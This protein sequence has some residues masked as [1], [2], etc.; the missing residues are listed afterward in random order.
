[1]APQFCLTEFDES[2]SCSCHN[3]TMKFSQSC[4]GAYTGYPES[5]GEACLGNY[6][7]DFTGERG[8]CKGYC[9]KAFANK[10]VERNMGV[11]T[12]DTCYGES[13]ATITY[14]REMSQLG[15]EQKKEAEVVLPVA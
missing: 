9:T 3:H 11:A 7:W 1:M 8:S 15:A 4:K 10:W 5:A 12:F 14:P 13:F 2:C 6:A